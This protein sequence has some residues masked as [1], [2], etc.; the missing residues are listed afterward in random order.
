M[1]HLNKTDIWLVDKYWAQLLENVSIGERFVT[2]SLC[3]WQELIGY[4]YKFKSI[5]WIDQQNRH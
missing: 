1:I 2:N 4:Y 3:F 5:D